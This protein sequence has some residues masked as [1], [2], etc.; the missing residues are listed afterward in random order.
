[1]MTR[2][3]HVAVFIPPPSDFYLKDVVDCQS[4]FTSPA[5][6]S[7]S[8][9]SSD[10]GDDN[11]SDGSS[12]RQRNLQHTIAYAPLSARE[13]VYKIES[14]EYAACGFRVIVARKMYQLLFQVRA[15][16]V[17]LEL[18][19]GFN[20]SIIA[21]EQIYLPCILFVCV[22]WVSF[23]IKPEMVPGRM[24]LLVTLFLVLVNIFNTV[25]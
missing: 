17:K 16:D 14:G 1:M 25:R 21:V 2:H 3:D 8:A 7:A 23:L 9:S 12:T 19:L 22:S 5:S 18:L 11:G 24:A 10:G 4:T 6:A 13:H 20:P 15:E